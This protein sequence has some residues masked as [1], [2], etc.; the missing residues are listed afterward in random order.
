LV[1]ISASEGIPARNL[2]LR[3]GP[4]GKKGERDRFRPVSDRSDVIERLFQIANQI[5]RIF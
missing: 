3:V 5:A 2:N 4:M 1:R